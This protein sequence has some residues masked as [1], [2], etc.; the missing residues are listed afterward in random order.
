MLPEEGTLVS[1]AMNRARQLQ[2]VP[3]LSVKLPGQVEEQSQVGVQ[4]NLHSCCLHAGTSISPSGDW[5][6][7]PWALGDFPE[8]SRAAFAAQKN[9]HGEWW[10]AGGSNPYP[11]PMYLP[12]QVSHLQG[13]TSSS[14]LDFRQPALRTPNCPRPQAFPAE[15]ETLALKA[16]EIETL[17]LKAH[18]S[19]LPMMQ[20]H[21]APASM[22]TA[23][24]PLTSQFWPREFVFTQ[25]CITNPNWELPSNRDH[26]PS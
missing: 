13:S 25:Y 4:A 14:L 8:R 24:L 21:P 22:D 26:H 18:P 11:A 16:A 10:V 15:I 3:V 7:V 2:K 17:A 23:H 9:P 19:P 6:T 12:R 1:Q 5:R 20:G